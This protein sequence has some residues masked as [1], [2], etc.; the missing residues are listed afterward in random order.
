MGKASNGVA[1]EM[2]C[3]SDDALLVLIEDICDVFAQ[4][5]RDW[6]WKIME[7]DIVLGT[8]QMGGALYL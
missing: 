4:R 1:I 2:R 6:S 7:I 3:R 5:I 8:I